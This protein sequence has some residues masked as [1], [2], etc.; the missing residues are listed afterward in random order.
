[1]LSRLLTL[2]LVLG[3]AYFLLTQAGP[4]IQ[5]QFGGRASSVD[6][7][8]SSEDG[9]CIELAFQANDRL[10]RVARQYGQPPVDVDAWSDAQWEIDSEIQTA[11]SACFCSAEACRSASEALS[12]MRNLV[13]NLDGMVRGTSPGFANP[14]N[15]QERIYDLL[16]RARSAAGY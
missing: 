13:S 16:N 6:V 12:E 8:A 15:Q 2:A 9:R 11:E 14:A 5:K 1:M 10:N 4:L 7:D 3:V